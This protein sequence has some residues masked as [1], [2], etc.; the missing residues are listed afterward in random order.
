MTRR[1]ALV[2]AA[3]VLA[4]IS[5]PVALAGIDSSLASAASREVHARASYYSNRF[6][7]RETANGERYD[8]NAM[9]AAHPTLPFGTRIRVK[10]AETRRAVVVRINDRGPYVRG[11]SLD[12][13]R[14]AAQLLGI[15]D[16]GVADVTLQILSLPSK[17]DA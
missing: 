15:A 2:L 10:S 14:R 11:R 17:R 3:V 5:T 1:I 12:L 6:V 16:D 13:S 8:A 7:G 9:T 4:S